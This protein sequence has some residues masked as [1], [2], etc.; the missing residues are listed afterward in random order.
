MSV[1]P[2]PL[3]L[4]DGGNSALK[5]QLIA[6]PAQAS[7]QALQQQVLQM[8][9]QRVDNASVRAQLLADAWQSAWQSSG[10]ADDAAWS[11]SWVCVG[12]TSVR[13]EVQLAFE[14]LAAS[15]SP[16][17]WTA[18][19]TVRLSLPEPL[20]FDNHY[21]DA[22][23]L[24]AD[25]WI[26]AL[27]LAVQGMIGQGETHMVVSAGTATTIDI[28]RVVHEG[29]LQHVQFIGGWILPGV[30]MMHASLHSGARDLNLAVHLDA[31]MD[32]AVPT[33]SRSAMEQGVALAQTSV[34]RLLAHRHHVTK[35]WLHGGGAAAWR[36]WLA[37]LAKEEAVGLT[38]HDQPQLAFLGLAA[39]ARLR[40]SAG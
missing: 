37:D 27:G 20:A 33:N 15:P 26:S 13:D 31:P 17:P 29:E 38:V 25:R 23:Q 5:W 16:A 1:A 2:T 40:R 12:P 21:A 19:K 28:V 30:R 14:R 35:L 11:L 32:A 34:L 6:A 3:L 7:A 18:V 36:S 39:M 8:P 10:G 4:V 24:G 9:V 22:Q